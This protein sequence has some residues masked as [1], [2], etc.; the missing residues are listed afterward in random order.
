MIK[1]TPTHIRNRFYDTLAEMDRNRSLYVKHPDSIAGVEDYKT[2]ADARA[3]KPGDLT[4]ERD[5]ESLLAIE[6]K[7]KT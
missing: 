7:D 4:V 1:L 6:V 5:G 3:G 2:A